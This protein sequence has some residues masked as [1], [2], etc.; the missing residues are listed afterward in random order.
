[1]NIGGLLT[2]FFQYT[3]VTQVFYIPAIILTKIA[4]VLFFMRVFPGREFRWLCLGTVAH[5]AMFMVSTTIAAI[6]ACIPVQ[7]AWT[8]WSGTGE[9]V[10]FDNNAYWWAHSVRFPTRTISG[11]EDENVFNPIAR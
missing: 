6:L 8:S 3:W 1:M 4:I 7:Y 10:C 2:L 9:G 11:G 5:C